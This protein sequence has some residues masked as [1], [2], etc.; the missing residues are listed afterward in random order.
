MREYA[1][2][3]DLI[4]QLMPTLNL[5]VDENTG[6][7]EQNT[8][9]IYNNI[10]AYKRQAREQAKQAYYA[11]IVEEI[12]NVEKKRYEAEMRLYELQAK[13]EE[14]IRKGADANVLYAAAQALA[15]GNAEEFWRNLSEEDR[16]LMQVQE[17]ISATK[18]ALDEYNTEI[19]Q[20]TNRLNE[21]IDAS[22]RMGK[23]TE[24]MYR[25]LANAA[26]GMKVTVETTL[27]E[28][29]IR[30]RQLGRDS[31]Y[32]VAKGV[33][34]AIPEVES[35]WV[36]LAKR[37]QGA[38]LHTYDQH[39][40]SRVMRAKGKDS[41]LGAALGVEDAIPTFEKAWAKFAEAGTSQYVQDQLDAAAAYPSIMAG[42][43]GYGGGP[44]NNTRNVAY[45]GISI[46]INTQP[47]Q[48]E[49]AIADAVIE[50]LT[51]ALG[52]EEAVF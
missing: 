50:Q 21:A 19:D 41:G 20:H 26:G 18:Q 25:D 1:A 45:G 9:Q 7:L 17:E 8:E 35:A 47:G 44:T 46:H 3:I 14:L 15:S 38:Y 5:T 11:A 24:D 10:E 16:A 49:R 31:G 12:A 36:K 22:E 13:Q 29:V 40:P 27:E 42:T 52:Q 37:G 4:N 51:A 23:S 32:G 6:R 43:P 34:D 2:T 30:A 33:R 48:D 39:S 28:L